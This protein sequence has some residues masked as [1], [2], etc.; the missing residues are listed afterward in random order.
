[1]LS[2]KNALP[3]D[4]YWPFRWNN[5]WKRDATHP[6]NT[7]SVLLFLFCFIFCSESEWI[8]SKYRACDN[9]HVFTLS[10]YFPIFINKLVTPRYD[11]IL[12]QLKS[13]RQFSNGSLSRCIINTN[14]SRVYTHDWTLRSITSFPFV[15][16]KFFI[17][18]LT[19]HLSSALYRLYNRIFNSIA[20]INL[21]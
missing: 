12:L 5:Q 15:I 19:A 14:T 9:M 20:T 18:F 8:S 7:H 13:S 1:M 17:L 2:F 16:H 11:I 3:I 21:F 4:S 10:S 6:T